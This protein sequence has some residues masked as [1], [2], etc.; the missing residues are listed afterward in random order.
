MYHWKVW[1][2]R[3]SCKLVITPYKEGIISILYDEK[4]KA[5]EMHFCKKEHASL[6]GNIYIGR[7]KDVVKHIHGAFLDLGNGMKAYYPL[8]DKATPFY[9][10]KGSSAN[11][12]QGDELLVQIKKEAVKTKDPAVTSE[13]SISSAYFV[14]FLNNPAIHYSGKM[15]QEAKERIKCVLSE[16][17]TRGFGIIVRTNA[18]DASKEELAQDLEHLC[19]RMEELKSKAPFR[20]A[21]TLLY[22]MPGEYL[23]VIKNTR[24]DQLE[25]IL[26]DD[27]GLYDEIRDYLST[28]QP[29]LLSK[30]RLYQDRLL[31]LSSLYSVE[32]R[33]EEAF[34]EKIWLKCGGYLVIQETEALTVVDVNSGK[35]TSSKSKEDSFLKINLEAA[36]E[37]ARQLRLRNIS[38]II[39]IDFI[40]MKS[41]ESEKLLLKAFQT[42]LDQDPLKAKVVDITPLGLVEM[43]RQRTKG[44]IREQM[45]NR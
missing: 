25:E 28:S 2:K 3:L 19:C 27:P 42:I 41:K 14:A 36:E 39:I 31:P 26:T 23:N 4:Q 38:G 13:I 10:R 15:S 33:V 43:T 20:P 6:S 5:V 45:K 21:G 22:Q 32:T 9:T 8:D 24:M 30:L 11:I 7:V 17:D 16:L 12:Q 40:N 35:F 29:V 1:V 44:T 34:Q 37:T 18:E